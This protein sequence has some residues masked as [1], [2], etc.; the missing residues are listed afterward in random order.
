MWAIISLI[1]PYAISFTIPLLITSLGGLI[2][3]R[4]G[5]VNIGLE[6]L[7]IVGAC[8]TILGIVLTHSVWLALLIAIFFCVLA[9]ALLWVVIEKLNAMSSPGGG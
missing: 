8:A 9:S 4:S 6:G 2:C 7:M 1:F 5:V 3:E